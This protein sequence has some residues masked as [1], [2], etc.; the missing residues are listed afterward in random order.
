MSPP[1]RLSG[2]GSRSP[3]AH[4]GIHASRREQRVVRRPGEGEHRAAMPMQRRQP[5]GV[6]IGR[7]KLRDHARHWRMRPRGARLQRRLEGERKHLDGWEAIGGQQTHGAT[8]CLIDLTREVG[9]D[10]AERAEQRLLLRHDHRARLRLGKGRPPGKQQIGQDGERILVRRRLH[11]PKPLLR[12]N[13]S[14]IRVARFLAQQDAVEVADLNRSGRDKQ[15]VLEFHPPMDD[16]ALVGTIERCGDLPHDAGNRQRS[17]VGRG[18]HVA[19]ERAVLFIGRDE[20]QHPRVARPP[21][22]VE[23]VNVGM[24]QRKQVLEPSLYLCEW[25]GQHYPQHFHEHHGALGRRLLTVGGEINVGERATPEQCGDVPTLD[26]GVCQ[27]ES[28]RGLRAH[29]MWRYILPHTVRR[30]RVQAD[31]RA[32]ILFHRQP[33]PLLCAL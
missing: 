6:K 23:W 28:T 7:G 15:T 24:A 27:Q 14:P 32:T 1:R 29:E 16:L 2:A 8:K 17:Q 21:H 19:R 33:H 30:V 20:V 11:L 31:T 3:Q 5:G 18:A 13:G 25:F 26:D 22:T 12:G 9:A 4:D 10:L